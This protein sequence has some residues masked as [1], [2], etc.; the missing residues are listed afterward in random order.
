MLNHRDQ[1]MMDRYTM[2]ELINHAFRVKLVHM[3]RSGSV[4][5]AVD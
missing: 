5:A 2:L 1:D 3:G 4:L